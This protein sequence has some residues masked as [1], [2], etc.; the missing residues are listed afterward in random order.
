MCNGV[1]SGNLIKEDSGLMVAEYEQSAPHF[2][3]WQQQIPQRRRGSRLRGS[4]A[5]GS[6]H[7]GSGIAST[8][9]KKDTSDECISSRSIFWFK[10]LVISPP[11]LGV[12]RETGYLHSFTRRGT[13]ISDEFCII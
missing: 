5:T 2:D 13:F 1:R 11:L 6:G 8:R 3:L 7:A 12:R 4:G 9:L 10:K